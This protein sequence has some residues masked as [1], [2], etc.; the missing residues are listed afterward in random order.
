MRTRRDQVQAYRFVTRR[1]VSALVSGEPESNDLPMRRLGLAL[2]GSVMV[3]GLVLG[4]FGAY[5]LLTDN[6]APL[7]DDS[8]VIDKDT[9]AK[10]VYLTKRLFPVA[11]Y[12]SARL[13][14]GTENPTIRR[15]SSGSLKGMPRGRTVGIVNAPD[16]LPDPKNLS[17]N[18]WRVCSNLTLTEG[19]VPVSSLVVGQSL[20]GAGALGDE[21]VLTY[22]EDNSGQ[23]NYYLVW[24]SMRL[25]VPQTTAV[26][27]DDQKA[28]KVSEQLINAI[29]AGPDLKLP[30]VSGMGSRF[31]G[32]VGG[33]QA[34]IGNVYRVGDQAY[35]L[36]QSGLSRIGNLTA[37]LLKNNGRDELDTTAVEA[38]RLKTDTRI[39]PEG[40]PGEMP[41]LSK[42]VTTTS[43]GAICNFYDVGTG[44][45]VVEVYATRPAELTAGLDTSN[46]LS[47]PGATAAVDRVLLTGGSGALI[48]YSQN[49]KAAPG[50]T[51]FLLTDSGRKY[52]LGTEGGSALDALGYKGAT[53]SPVPAALGELIEVGPTLQ[54]STARQS[55]TNTPTTG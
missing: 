18:V 37:E 31:S 33:S 19:S 43:N 53:I 17:G 13:I 8:L 4:G 25:K 7:A 27:L 12:A 10:Y 11:N 46:S 14:L 39:E 42:T 51:V 35:V 44:K 48:Q 45:S 21:A 49:G 34:V 28:V 38:E 22:F 54:I 26:N 1:I 23:L 47:V 41:K 55:V 16:A 29:Q 36:T 15:V 30:Q 20:S 50:N 9:G 3:A 24:N 52:P 2:V 5:G 6:R 40:F 32:T